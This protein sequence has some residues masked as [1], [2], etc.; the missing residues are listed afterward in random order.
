KT[1]P[2]C[3]SNDPA[4]MIVERRAKL[5]HQAMKTPRAD[6][7]VWPEMI[8]ELLL[9][10]RLRPAL[11]E[12]NQEFECFRR[13]RQLFPATQELTRGRIDQKRRETSAHRYRKILGESRPVTRP[14]PTASV[15][16]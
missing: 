16:Q 15:D 7:C 4:L 8:V 2:I 9:R 11:D 13:K 6:V 12:H 5:M 10:N 14:Y 1:K 3:R